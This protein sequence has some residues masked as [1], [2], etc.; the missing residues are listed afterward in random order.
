[1]RPEY[2]FE[3]VAEARTYLSSVITDVATAEGQRELERL[4]QEARIRERD[5]G[6]YVLYDAI[7]K[8]VEC[9][10]GSVDVI[11]GVQVQEWI[12]DDASKYRIAIKCVGKPPDLW[13]GR[14]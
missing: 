5:D 10:N 12:E 9:R 8:Y 6:Y 3:T 7:K 14:H 4:Y 13:R 2:D 11:E 1:M